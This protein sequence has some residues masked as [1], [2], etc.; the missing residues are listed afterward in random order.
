MV[1]DL[2]KY[3]SILGLFAT[4]SVSAIILGYDAAKSKAPILYPTAK[5]KNALHMLRIVKSAAVGYARP[6]MNPSAGTNFSMTG[7]H[8]LKCF[9]K[10]SAAFSFNSGVKM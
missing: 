7:Y 3:A 1:S 2:A 10:S 5:G 6:L 8:L 9:G 4:R